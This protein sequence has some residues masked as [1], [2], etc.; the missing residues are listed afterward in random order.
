MTGDDLKVMLL[1][2]ADGCTLAQR[3]VVVPLCDFTI[4][5]LNMTREGIL[6]SEPSDGAGRYRVRAGSHV[7]LNLMVSFV[8]A[9]KDWN[10]KE[11]F[12]VMSEALKDYGQKRRILAFVARRI[13]KHAS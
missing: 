6:Y 9:I 2:G 7:D 4:S 10:E 1:A 13:S 8:S 5:L 12:Y 3:P 11:N